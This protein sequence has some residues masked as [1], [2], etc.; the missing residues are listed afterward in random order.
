MQRYLLTRGDDFGSFSEANHAIRDAFN[1]GI[2]RS[3]SLMA[4]TP[5]YREAAE[6]A[7]AMPG[8]CLGL[9]LTLNCEWDQV[10]WGP[11]SDPA[12]VPSLVDGDGNFLSEPLLIHQRGVVL[13][14][15]MRELRAQ[16]ARARADG[17]T[18]SYL[19]DHMGF[20]WIH[21]AGNQ[22][23]LL[24]AIRAWAHEE[25]LIFHTDVTRADVPSLLK[26]LPHP[27]D[28]AVVAERIARI[29][30]GI[31]FL[32]THP[33][34]HRGT[35]PTLR[36]RG[37]PDAAIGKEAAIRAADAA[38][39]LDP[40]IRSACDRHGVTLV[41]YVEASRALADLGREARATARGS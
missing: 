32:H 7:R 20:S 18:I 23:R 35:L 11:V 22:P 17:L 37:G 14:E 34:Y 31:A 2:L 41:S 19:D 15:A 24:Q 12:L 39:L 36:P 9:H 16:L 4:P 29:E 6:F 3:A 13:A 27:Y 40:T 25:G 33:A 26:D 5:A 38:I 21:P 28:P 8:L 1:R 10:R 30:P